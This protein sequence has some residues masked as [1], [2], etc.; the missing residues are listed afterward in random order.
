M[1]R[2]KVAVALLLAAGLPAACTGRLEVHCTTSEQCPEG[3]TCRDRS[4]DYGLDPAEATAADGSGARDA[5][6]SDAPGTEAAASATCAV[7]GC[8]AGAYC[9]A[10][11]TCLACDT[12]LHCGDSCAP[13]P[14]QVAK[15]SGAKCV[16]C[17]VNADCP[18]VTPRCCV[19]NVCVP[20]A[21]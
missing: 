5:A 16:Q 3:E 7:A 8:A 6:T 4:C 12:E 2:A 11:E 19:A 9:G 1:N 10:G 13:C 21:C 20:G 14:A 15:C 17:L 18:S